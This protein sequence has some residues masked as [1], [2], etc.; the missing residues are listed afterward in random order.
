LKK[1]NNIIKIFI[2][3]AII[4][5]FSGC[6][7]NHDEKQ[8]PAKKVSLKIWRLFDSDEIM[9][10]IID[11]FIADRSDKYDLTIE[12]K[13]KDYKEYVETTTNALAAGEG[14]DIWMIRNDW[15]A[16]EY[17]KLEPLPENILT[18][19]QYKNLFPEIVNKDNIIDNKIYGIPWS[20]D[21]L[22]LYYNPQIFAEAREQIEDAGIIDSE[23]DKIL[24][25]PPSN[26][27]ELIRAV[28][29]LT[30]K[31]GD[32]IE[33]AG[34][35]MGTKNNVDHSIDILTALMLQNHTQMVSDD[36]LTATFNLAINKE[37]GKPVYSGTKALE[38]Y[39]SFSHPDKE[40]YTWNDSMPNSVQAFISG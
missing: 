5:S 19:E 20:V 21:T 9:Q 14:P 40:V 31:N 27:E 29:Y 35:A 12:Y 7:N 8:A 18:L 4:F 11:E 34:I 39:K 2:I 15:V 38:F 37:S 24:E 32:N 33:R 30:K 1:I 36:L 16:R 23:N 10:P 26:W 22:A 28:K 6:N 13:Q 3:I 17:D 25:E